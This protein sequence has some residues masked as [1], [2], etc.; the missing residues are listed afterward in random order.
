MMTVIEFVSCYYTACICWYGPG[1]TPLNSPPGNIGSRC[2][3]FSSSHPIWENFHDD[4]NRSCSVLLLL[5]WA[6][7]CVTEYNPA[8][9]TNSTKV[10]SSVGKL[11]DYSPVSFKLINARQP[12]SERNSL[13][14]INHFSALSLI[15]FTCPL[16]PQPRP[17]SACS[18]S[19]TSGSASPG[20]TPR[21]GPSW[22]LL[23]PW[24][25]RRGKEICVE[26]MVSVASWW[27]LVHYYVDKAALRSIV[28]WLAR[29]GLREL[30]SRFLLS[31]LRLP[32]L[33]LRICI[34]D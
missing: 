33:L 15:T 20:Q 13:K 17:T 34:F 16:P 21:S 9:C 5:S 32:I 8:A 11:K 2:I 23:R 26:V 3:I 28:M 27:S 1:K 6:S 25:L 18:S 4:R 29:S 24:S 30:R 10:K 14:I 19:Q 22:P 7:C 12:L 31:F